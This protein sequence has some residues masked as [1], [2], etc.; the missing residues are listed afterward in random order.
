MKTI[1]LDVPVFA[2]VVGTRVALA[3]GVGLLL[4]EKLPARRR[5]A[6]G[7]TLI[8]I[9]A[10]STLPAAISVVKGLRE[11]RRR[12]ES[13]ATGV[14]NNAG[15]DNMVGAIRFPRRGNGGVRSLS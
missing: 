11:S 5:R 10:A 4:S 8:A 6:I 1:A 3:A 9:G 12:I 14:E 2:F 7:A 13:D 15:D